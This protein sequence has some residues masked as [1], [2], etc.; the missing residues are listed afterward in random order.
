MFT[1]T[2]QG[3]YGSEQTP[4]DIYVYGGWYVVDGSVN[5]NH[6]DESLLVDGVDVEW[7][8]D[9]DTFTWNE[10]IESEDELE[11]AVDE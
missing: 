9:D 4:T 3:T 5:V 2:I 8:P 1:R 10:P 7:L 11:S 6:T